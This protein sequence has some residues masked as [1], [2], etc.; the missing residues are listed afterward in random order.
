MDY[1][2][3]ENCQFNWIIKEHCDKPCKFAIH[4][5]TFLCTLF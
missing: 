5:C 4:K 2:C 1:G 3:I